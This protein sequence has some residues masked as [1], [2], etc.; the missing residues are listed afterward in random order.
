MD[1]TEILPRH[2]EGW[3]AHRM[4][5]PTKYGKR[6]KRTTIKTEFSVLRAAM[7]WA[8]KNRMIESNPASVVQV[9]KGAPRERRV[10][11]QDEVTQLSLCENG[12]IWTLAI[13]TG[14]RRTEILQLRADDVIW[15]NEE[16][17][18]IVIRSTSEH[19]TKSGKNRTVPLNRW[20]QGALSKLL[21]GDDGQG[22]VVK[23]SA[24]KLS[25]WFKADCRDLGIPEVTLHS[26]RHTFI[27]AY[28][29]SPGNLIQDAMELAGHANI[30]TTMIYVHTD[31]VSKVKGVENL[32]F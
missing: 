29:N 20:A 25:K 28:A 27:S 12:A 16:P 17:S 22:F 15:E 32:S 3:I 1:I 9:P 14:M 8:Y 26:T 2:I 21:L 6:R 23:A 10:L 30:E 7:M 19:R 13:H 4:T 11:T 31:P 5:E 18:A 24:T